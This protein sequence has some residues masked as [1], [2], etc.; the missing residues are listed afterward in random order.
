MPSSIHLMAASFQAMASCLTL[1]AHGSSS[2]PAPVHLRPTLPFWLS[3]AMSRLCVARSQ[4]HHPHA[5]TTSPHMFMP[6]PSPSP[7]PVLT[8][9]PSSHTCPACPAVTL[10]MCCYVYSHTTVVVSVLPL[11][12]ELSPCPQF[13]HTVPVHPNRQSC[14]AVASSRL[15]L[16][17]SIPATAP[18]INAPQSFVSCPRHLCSPTCCPGLTCHLACATPHPTHHSGSTHADTPRPYPHLRVSCF[19]RLVA[20]SCYSRRPGLPITLSYQS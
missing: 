8:A 17:L 10:A 6:T 12:S 15:H 19:V 2:A 3:L 16:C 14:L 7:C 4:S 9:V 13:T 1:H 11:A 18:L 5:E 20:L